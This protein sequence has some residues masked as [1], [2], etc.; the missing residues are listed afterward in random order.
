M[1]SEYLKYLKSIIVLSALGLLST[2][3]SGQAAVDALKSHL[4]NQTVTVK[5]QGLR[6]SRSI[7][8]RSVDVRIKDGVIQER[9][10]KTAADTD[11]VLNPGDKVRVTKVEA[12]NE[13]KNDFLRITI[14]SADG[15]TVPVAFVFPKGAVAGQDES[16]LE[17]VIGATFDLPN[18]ASPAMQPI[19]PPP[20]P[21]DSPPTAPALSAGWRVQV[22]KD[23]KEAAIAGVSNVNGRQV[24][25]V[26]ALT[27]AGAEIRVRRNA[28]PDPKNLDCVGDMDG[29]NDVVKF[30]VGERPL[31]A[32]SVCAPDPGPGPSVVFR[33]PID[34][35]AGGL[36]EVIS[37][38][39]STMKFLVDFS[40]K[41]GAFTAN[42]VTAEFQLPQD[43][44][45]IDFLRACQ[46][47]IN[48]DAQPTVDAC[49][50]LPG[51]GLRKVELLT[52]TGKPY[53]GPPNDND[54][55]VE[56]VIP[57]ATK[58]HPVRPKLHFVCYYGLGRKPT[59]PQEP[60]ERK[61]IPISASATDCSVQ[62]DIAL[63][64]LQASCVSS[65]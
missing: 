31:E 61:I 35:G 1:K 33:M 65:K 2:M 48:Y 49:P 19:A 7:L 62:G 34:L 53:V 52:A 47:S 28:V 50:D 3:A 60:L 29:G 30:S 40:D 13:K 17:Q 37:S 57:K 22:V 15:L 5:I 36:D 32:A 63:G 54:I 58:A 6:I 21:P 55:G 4:V 9:L 64:L 43:A 46:K 12:T 10:F 44:S 38:P 8:Y 18:T 59:D 20:P 51:K 14:A 11:E 16:Q 26:M 39:G 56:W 42:T 45:P 25:A 23:G 41:P 27:C 24:Q